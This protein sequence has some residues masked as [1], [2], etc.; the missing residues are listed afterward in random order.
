MAT[1]TPESRSTSPSGAPLFLT[2]R[3][4]CEIAHVTARTIARW[5]EDGRFE[6]IRPVSTG[7]GRRL[8]DRASFLAF[9]GRVEAGVA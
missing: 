7:S 3:Q 9:L 8:V 6:S 2:T 4:C 5:I 1:K